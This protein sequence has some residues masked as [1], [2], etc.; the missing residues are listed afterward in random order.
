MTSEIKT[1]ELAGVELDVQA[2]FEATV[3]DFGIGSYEHFGFRGTQ[4][5]YGWEIESVDIVPV[6]SVL[7]SVNEHLAFIGY[8]TR[9]H[10]RFIKARRRLVKQVE[11]ALKRLDSESVYTND[12]LVEAAGEVPTF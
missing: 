8:P 1:I 3:Q 2:E 11:R 6:N 5:A 10:R 12:E 4:H 7:D 9:N